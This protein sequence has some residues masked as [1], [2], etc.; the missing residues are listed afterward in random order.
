FFFSYPFFIGNCDATF[1]TERR[2]GQN[3]IKTFGRAVLKAIISFNRWLA[4]NNPN[5]VK[6]HVHHTKPRSGSHNFPTLEVME[7]HK[8]LLL[9]IQSIALRLTQVFIG[10]QEKAAGAA[11]RIG[12]RTH[13]FRMQAFNHSLY[14]RS[15]GKVLPRTT[16]NVLSIFLQQ[17]FIYVP[18]YI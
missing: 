12:Y 2:I 9:F 13:R 11:G 15:G 5:A 7:L 3:I 6:Y 14:E 16:L 8:L 18:F 1:F 4:V 17:P 10:S